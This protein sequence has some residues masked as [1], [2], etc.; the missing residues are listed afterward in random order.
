MQ[1]SIKK[2]SAIYFVATGGVAAL[3]SKSVVKAD[4]I[5]FEDLGPEAIYKFEIEDMPVIV[6]IDSNGDNIFLEDNNVFGFRYW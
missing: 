1:N 2:N 6:G 4:L 5:A 3:I